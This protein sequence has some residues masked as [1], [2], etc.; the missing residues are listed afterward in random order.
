VYYRAID[1]RVAELVMLARSLTADNAAALAA[2]TR[3][4]AQREPAEDGT[5]EDGTAED[6][7]GDAE[8]AL[9]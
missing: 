5:A 6:G 3:I 2:C 9:Q 8:V 1:P 4:P 7:L